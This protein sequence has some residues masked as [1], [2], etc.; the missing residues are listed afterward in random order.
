MLRDPKIKNVV[1]DRKQLDHAIANIET[2]SSL[3]EPTKRKLR[4]YMSINLIDEIAS[5]GEAYEIKVSDKNHPD[6][7]YI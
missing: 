7:I 2:L 3:A 6:L 5:S 1:Q 4:S